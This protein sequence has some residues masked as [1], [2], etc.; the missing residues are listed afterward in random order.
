MFMVHI[1]V[2]ICLIIGVVRSG[3]SASL[4]GKYPFSLGG[5]VITPI[6]HCIPSTFLL[7]STL[8]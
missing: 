6:T 4:K 2:R 5:F 8:N 7:L 1:F 3:N